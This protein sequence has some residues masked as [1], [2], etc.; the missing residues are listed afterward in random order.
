[1]RI[2]FWKEWFEDSVPEVTSACYAALNYL[3][4]KGATVVPIEIPHLRYMS[5]AHAAK[6][7]GEF[8]VKFDDLLH[9]NPEALEP[10][11]KVTV[12]VGS[13]M[14]ALEVLAG[15]R[16][17]AW[18]FDYVDELMQ[19]EN[20]SCI[21]NPTIAVLPPPLREDA[22]IHGENNNPL[23]IQLMKYIFLGNY[24][25]LPGWSVNVG[26]DIPQDQEGSRNPVPI[27]LHFLGKHW[28]ED[29]LFRLGH[30]LE[31]WSENDFLVPPIF[32]D[33]FNLDTLGKELE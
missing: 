26:Y 6:I 30:A 22:R 18:A 8:A 9:N 17:R 4:S 11:T 25:G 19:K 12:G 20:L 1:M 28:G 31:M 15:E 5:L 13:S 24:L 16:L 33:P 7:T 2:G 32:H 23:T 21:I 3:E 10:N 14:T 27:G 29:V